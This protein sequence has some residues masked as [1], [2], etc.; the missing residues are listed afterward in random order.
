MNNKNHDRTYGSEHTLEEIAKI[1]G[2]T[3]ER[4]RQI[5]RT[6]LKKMKHP[7]VSKKLRAYLEK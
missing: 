5:E 2:M 4:V 1:L 6:A 7:E 3:R